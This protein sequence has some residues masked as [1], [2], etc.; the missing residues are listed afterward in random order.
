[1]FQLPNGNNVYSTRNKLI[2][3]N[4]CPGSALQVCSGYGNTFTYTSAN[5]IY[6]AGQIT[7]ERKANDFTFLA[8]YTFAK[9]L[10]DSSGFG[11]LV[12]FVNPKLSRGYPLR[13]SRTILWPVTFGP[14]RSIGVSPMRQ[15]LDPGLAAS[16]NHPLVRRLSGSA[17][18]RKWRLHFVGQL[19]NAICPTG[20]SSADPESAKIESELPNRRRYGMLLHS[21]YARSCDTAIPGAHKAA[22]LP[23]VGGFALNC[24]PGTF[25]TAD[26]RFFHGP[27][28]NNT[29]FGILKR[30]R[31]KE[32]LAFDLR[33]EFFNIFNHAQF[34]N[35]TGNITNRISESSLK[36]AIPASGRLARNS[37][38]S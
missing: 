38:C 28:F 6:N 34:M 17:K 13:T 26:R 22:C 31:I 32:S 9:A 33:F 37:T 19:V 24:V 16:G 12:N 4:Y 1:M 21:A 2:N 18:P 36:R 8:A 11:D 14:S 5:S 15:A 7:V 29:D 3:P 25:G 35:P 30:T 20:W 23:S 27:G 10:D